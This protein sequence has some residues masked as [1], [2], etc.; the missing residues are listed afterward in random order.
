MPTRFPGLEKEPLR[1][2]FWP[3]GLS[4]TPVPARVVSLAPG[5]LCLATE[6]PPVPGARFVAKFSVAG[7]F[8]IVAGCQAR[9]RLERSAGEWWVSAT[10][11]TLAARD[12]HVLF[13]AWR[14]HLG[15]P[16]RQDASPEPLAAVGG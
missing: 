10:F 1:A 2:E 4:T 11:L 8:P 13:E 7:V 5:V 9:W 3:E 15:A 16:E 6:T 12:W 14:E